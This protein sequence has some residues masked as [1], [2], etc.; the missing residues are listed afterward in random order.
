MG[1]KLQVQASGREEEVVE[2]VNDVN[3]TYND[4]PEG[5]DPRATLTFSNGAKVTVVLSFEEGEWSPLFKGDRDEHTVRNGFAHE[6]FDI[7]V[8]ALS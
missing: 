2:E 8:R 3:V 4:I 1:E 6:V 5:E 7:I